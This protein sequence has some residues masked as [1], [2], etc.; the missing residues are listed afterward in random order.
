MKHQRR[1]SNAFSLL[2]LLTVMAI[3]GIIAAVVVPRLSVSANAASTA[4][5]NHAQ[6]Q[7]NTAIERYHI[8][9]NSTWPADLDALAPDYLSDG[10]PTKA[11][12]S[13]WIY[14]NDGANPTYRVN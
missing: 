11:D 10:I 3:L 2:E 4:L 12:G 6:S 14:D 7:L 8:D 9:H 1:R 13:A 5:D